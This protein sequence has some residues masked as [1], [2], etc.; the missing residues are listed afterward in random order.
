MKSTLRLSRRIW[1]EARWPFRLALIMSLAAGLSAIGLLALSGWFV[2]ATAAA[3]LAGI[4]IAFDVFAPSAGIRALAFTRTAARYG[5][6]L[7]GHQAAL[8]GLARLRVALFRAEA[9]AAPNPKSRVADRLALLSADIDAVEG[10]TVRAVLP[11]L[12]GALALIGTAA[13]VWAVAGGAIAA[14]L[15]GA[16]LLGFLAA[17]AISLWRVAPSA[18][19]AETARLTLRHAS[20]DAIHHRSNLTAEGGL[21]AARTALH[22]EADSLRLARHRLTDAELIA[23]SLANLGTLAGLTL[24]FALSANAAVAGTLAVPQILLVSLAALG[25]GEVQRGLA[26]A[27]LEFARAARSA[28]RIDRALTHAP[29]PC[30]AHAATPVAAAPLIE[31]ASAAPARP[32]LTGSLLTPV[33]LQL[34]P[35][36]SLQLIAPSGTGKSTLLAAIAGRAPLASGEVRLA[37]VAL[38]DWPEPDLRQRLMLVSQRPHLI[39]GSLRDNLALA[40]DVSDEQML[41]ALEAVQLADTV[42]GKG[43]LEAQLG[44]RGAGLSGGEARR[45]ALARALLRQPDILLLDEPTEGL[46]ASTAEAV[47][48]GIRA[49]LPQAALII[50]T[51]R[52]EDFTGATQMVYLTGA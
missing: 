47:L 28:A 25:F 51:H 19:A 7:T 42:A 33:S 16:N 17:S 48:S 20:L 32:G 44:E 14:A 36:E 50:A 23:G 10:L 45:L 43:G 2:T 26:G 38:E 52:P 5:E 21:N 39:G 41:A 24:A 46:D 11:L 3:G 8:S 9:A 1:H 49:A 27:M 4:G 13:L 12:A 31:L 15:A 6:R 29:E 18:R 40:G 22:R 30:A 35:G 37:G 34:D